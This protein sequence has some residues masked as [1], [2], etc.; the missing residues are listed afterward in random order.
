MQQALANTMRKKMNDEQIISR[1]NLR[2][3]NM[4][5]GPKRGSMDDVLMCDYLEK[6]INPYVKNASA[7]L[8]VLENCRL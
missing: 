1:V 6:I 7:S 3:R 8:L 5:S 2:P 4:S